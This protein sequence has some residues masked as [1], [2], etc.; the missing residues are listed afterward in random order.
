MYCIIF[1]SHVTLQQEGNLKKRKRSQYRLIEQGKTQPINP[2]MAFPCGIW[3]KKRASHQRDRGGEFE[4]AILMACVA[5][6]GWTQ[7]Q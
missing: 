7:W 1:Y 4:V 2:M 6:Q 3:A 5:K